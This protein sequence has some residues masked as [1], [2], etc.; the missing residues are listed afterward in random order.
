METRG[1]WQGSIY[2][3]SESQNGTKKVKKVLTRFV[4]A[5]RLTL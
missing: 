1:K 2:A 4:S 5:P 3:G